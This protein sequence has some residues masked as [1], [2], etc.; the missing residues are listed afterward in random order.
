[1]MC[2]RRTDLDVVAMIKIDGGDCDDNDDSKV[3]SFASGGL[4][5]QSFKD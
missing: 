4:W 1:M 2:G 3:V 5:C